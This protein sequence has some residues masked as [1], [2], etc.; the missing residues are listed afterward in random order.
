MSD[1]TESGK[2]GKWGNWLAVWNFKGI[3][4]VEFCCEELL[5]IEL[6]SFEVLET[7]KLKKFV[8]EIGKIKYLNDYSKD[9][10]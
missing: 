9:L 8:N 4:C 5:L 3:W 1:R 7:K 10:T 2:T 6:F